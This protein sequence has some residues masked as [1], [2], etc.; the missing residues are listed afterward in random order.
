MEKAIIDDMYP[1]LNL[2]RERCFYYDENSDE[3]TDV[4]DVSEINSCTHRYGYRKVMGHTH[5]RRIQSQGSHAMKYLNYYPS[6]GDILRPIIRTKVH[7]NVITTPLGIFE[8]EYTLDNYNF[9]MDPVHLRQYYDYISELFYPMN[10]LTTNLAPGMS[11]REI[12]EEITP[13]FIIYMRD[14]CEVTEAFINEV[15]LKNFPDEYVFSLRYTPMTE[16]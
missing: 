9:I 11:L 1:A 8:A 2:P 4:T 15:I 14:T 12:Q 7:L 6:A 5:P 13:N 3:W 10:A 16:L